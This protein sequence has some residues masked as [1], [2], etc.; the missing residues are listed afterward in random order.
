MRDLRIVACPGWKVLKGGA[1]WERRY[2]RLGREVPWP[3][4]TEAALRAHADTFWA[5]AVW[6]AKKVARGE[7]RAAQREFHRVLVEKIWL[8]LEDEAR[9]R[10]P[11]VRPEARR[12]ERWL[13]PAQVAETAFATAPD[14]QAMTAALE[15]AADT[16]AAVCARLAVTRG[17]G[18]DDPTAL[19]RWLAS[20]APAAGKPR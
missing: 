3:R 12:A 15:E 4:L 13:P 1:A 14:A 8:V 11:Q 16:F 7:L 18:L 2:T 17:W 9:D 10:T 6:V 5:T 19:R 20:Q